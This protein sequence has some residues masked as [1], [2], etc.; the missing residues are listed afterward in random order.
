MSADCVRLV[1]TDDVSDF[2]TDVTKDMWDNAGKG[3]INVLVVSVNLLS[4][5][6]IKEGD[7]SA[8]VV[9]VN[10]L[11]VTDITESGLNVPTV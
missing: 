3:D 7:T 11:S 8:P 2:C 9:S 4:V 1:V 6:A 5:T 10:F